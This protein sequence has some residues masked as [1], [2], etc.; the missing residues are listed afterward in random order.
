MNPLTQIRTRISM[1]DFLKS[2][3]RSLDTEGIVAAGAEHGV[4]DLCIYEVEASLFH[5]DVD[6][7]GEGC[8]EIQGQ[9]YKGTIEKLEGILL[10]F[11]LCEGYTVNGAKLNVEG[12][13]GT[14]SEL[15]GLI[16]FLVYGKGL[17]F[18]P[19]DA[20]SETTADLDGYELEFCQQ[21]VDNA[22]E[23]FG[24]ERVYEITREIRPD[25]S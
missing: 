10:D 20:L 17:A 2:P 11:L 14:E 7:D 15:R 8:L 13:C 1:A 16:A 4:S 23:A 24:L 3:A 22:I 21:G 18:H 6:S 9:V 5:I 12:D 19:E 25:F